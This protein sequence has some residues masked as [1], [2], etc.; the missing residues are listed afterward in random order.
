MFKYLKKQN[1]F[2]FH[3][4]RNFGRKITIVTTPIY[5]INAAP[6]IGHLYTT[7]YA[8]AIKQVKLLEGEDDV[9]LT[10]GNDEHG[11]KIQN[12]VQ[13]INGGKGDECSCEG[14]L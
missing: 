4:L 5:Y 9:V 8:D 13:I 12:K 1:K 2:N 7:M 10:T 6:H 3:L 11:I 14:I